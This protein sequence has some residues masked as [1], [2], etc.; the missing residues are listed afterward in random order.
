MAVPDHDA[1]AALLSTLDRDAFGSY[2]AALWDARGWGVTRDGDVLV[3]TDGDVARRLLPVVRRRLRGIEPR[4]DEA[5]GVDVVVDRDGRATNAAAERGVG[6]VGPNDLRS[7]ALYGIDR[8][9]ADRLFREYFD[10]P[11]DD[12]EP[13][14]PPTRAAT[15]SG[16][17]ESR[18]AGRFDFSSAALIE[19]ASTL[20]LV[21]LVVVA[22]ATAAGVNP[23]GPNGVLGGGG[24]SVDYNTTGGNTSG[25]FS[26]GAVSGSGIS[27]AYPPGVTDGHVNGS[28]LAAA[29]AAFLSNRS[30]QVVSHAR[31]R[32][33]GGSEGIEEYVPTSSSRLRVEN[34]THYLSE[35][36]L[37]TNRSSGSTIGRQFET[38][39][40]GTRLYTRQVSE[41]QT[42][43]SRVLLQPRNAV[44]DTEWRLVEYMSDANAIVT[45]I[46]QD[47]ETRYRIVVTDPPK[48]LAS[49]SVSI[50]DYRAVAVVN[51]SGFVSRF[52]LQYRQV[53][54]FPNGSVATRYD[55]GFTVTDVGSTTVSPPGWY[56]AVRGKLNESS[57]QGRTVNESEINGTNVHGSSKDTETTKT[58]GT[59]G[60]GR[61]FHRVT[62]TD[63]AAR[64]NDT[65]T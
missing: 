30:Y 7:M 1:F 26:V 10:R 39:A 47:G 32:Q 50:R 38:Y 25:N 17:D 21:L 57:M 51:G 60:L 53:E 54:Q 55:S 3:A 52:D 63:T 49:G 16:G 5:D 28:A 20:V 22:G 45:P 15:R 33:V 59:T 14:A 8:D 44:D 34:A 48:S 18:E 43:Y 6:Y 9:D 61:T 11:I 64:A 12:G 19:R 42:K 24:G 35:S 58:S 29:Q 62:A 13:A 46:G 41:N 37:T 40:D 4:L 2:V 36:T 31:G 56:K 65:A 27:Q 23:L